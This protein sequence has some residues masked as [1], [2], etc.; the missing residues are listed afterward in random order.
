MST[1]EGGYW[2]LTHPAFLSAPRFMAKSRQAPGK[3]VV[4]R[5]EPFAGV[6]GPGHVSDAGSRLL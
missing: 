1:A 4:L 3:S 2:I 6:E 5:L